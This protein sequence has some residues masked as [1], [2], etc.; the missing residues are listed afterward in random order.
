MT[1]RKFLQ[2]K[3][4]SSHYKGGLKHGDGEVARQ[5]DYNAKKPLRN[6]VYATSKDLDAQGIIV[7]GEM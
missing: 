6:G 1:A 3:D 4:V 2:E 7:A 5:N